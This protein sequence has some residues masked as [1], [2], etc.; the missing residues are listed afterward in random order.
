VEGSA[1][2]YL[3]CTLL[4]VHSQGILPEPPLLSTK[5]RYDNENLNE[6]EDMIR[7]VKA[8]DECICDP[9]LIFNDIPLPAV[10][11]MN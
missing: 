4:F 10:I 5:A 8:L 1:G 11:W 3:A 6:L 7:N 9:L 2:I